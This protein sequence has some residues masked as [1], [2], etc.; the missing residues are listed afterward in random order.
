MPQFFRGITPSATSYY[1]CEG[2]GWE[3]GLD[4]Q[5]K[6][7][8]QFFSIFIMIIMTSII[9]VLIPN[10]DLFNILIWSQV[11]NGVFIPLILFFIV[12]LCNDPE[13][14]GEHTNSSWY[15]FFCYGIILLMS[16][17]NIGMIFIEL[18]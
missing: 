15:N 2:M 10:I 17:A 14:M 8:P 1:V 16:I 11:I 7:A 12:R 5:F 3:R 9:M 6:D 18:N 13:I 4:R